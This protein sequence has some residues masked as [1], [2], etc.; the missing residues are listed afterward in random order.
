MVSP[1]RQTV[2]AHQ[3]QGAELTAGAAPPI[4]RAPG[5]RP[6]GQVLNSNAVRVNA[7]LKPH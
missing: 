2:R 6:V 1:R 7:H 3:A 5:P 4:G